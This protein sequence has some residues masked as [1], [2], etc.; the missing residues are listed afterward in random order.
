MRFVAQHINTYPQSLLQLPPPGT[1]LW[2][3]LTNAR[4]IHVYSGSHLA[5]EYLPTSELDSN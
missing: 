3:I 4:S 5:N 2:I 1:R